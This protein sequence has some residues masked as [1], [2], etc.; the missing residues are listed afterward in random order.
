MAGD[1]RSCATLAGA[2]TALRE[3]IAAPLPSSARAEL[4]G[5][6]KRAISNL[7][8]AQFDEL[9]K[10]GRLVPMAEAISMAES[11]RLSPNAIR[12]HAGTEASSIHLTDREREVLALMASGMTDRQIAE[13][14]FISPRTVH[15]HVAGLYEKLGVHTRTAAVVASQTAGLL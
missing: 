10:A 5:A 7:G 12:K 8:Q 4:D 1:A 6:L 15:R 11:I 13:A 2:A 3:E 14:L 9:W